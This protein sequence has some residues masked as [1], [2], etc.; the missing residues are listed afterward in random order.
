MPGT[1]FLVA[2]PIGNLEDITMRALRVLKEV[3]LIAAE[4]TRR[5]AKLLTHFGI[6]TRTTSLH[7]HNEHETVPKLIS[8]L[9]SGTS[10]AVV[11]DAGMPVIS[12]PGYVL[13]A[14]AREA[15]IRV[16]AIPGASALT[17]AVAGAGL[18]AST[19]VFLGFPPARAGERKRWLEKATA[20][21]GTL[22]LFEAP[23]RLRA[24]LVAIA[25]VLG[26]RFVVVAHELT[27][28]HE[29]WHRGW[30]RE[31]AADSQ[32]PDRGEFT[33]LVSDQIHCP[34]ENLTTVADPV[35]I[36][37]EFRRMTEVDGLERRSALAHLAETF[38]LPKRA[39]YAMVEQA[40]ARRVSNL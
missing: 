7:E 16:E 6:G 21:P 34:T 32:L 29:S 22:V 24:T 39:I 8:R 38:S 28:I 9:Q 15:G 30:A 10:V 14:A 37:E 36:V 18:P 31:V 1:L 35:R 26:D 13:A 2:T 3:D 5:T 17:T 19:V 4:D 12:D 23:T 40:K 33:I 11:S 27:K 25:D 20:L